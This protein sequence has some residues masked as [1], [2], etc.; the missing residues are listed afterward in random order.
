MESMIGISARP[1]SVSAYSTRGGTS[2]YVQR[3]TT[4]SSSSARRRS[5]SV[6]GEIPASERSS[7]QNRERPSASS[8]TS[9][10]V[11]LPQTRSAVRQTGQDAST[12][13][14]QTLPSEV[15]PPPG[16]QPLSSPPRPPLPP[17]P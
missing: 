10:S 14:P 3:S 5:D 4:P 13:T 11:H 16:V 6:R 17:P 7:S 15:C 12:G 1:L 2:G 9:S 8:R